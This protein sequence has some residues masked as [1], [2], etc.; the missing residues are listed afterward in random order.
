M[1][2]TYSSGKYIRNLVF[3]SITWI[4]FLA[5]F[6]PKLPYLYAQVW[7]SDDLTIIMRLFLFCI[8]LFV[9]VYCLLVPLY[10]L[11]CT[12]QFSHYDEDTIINYDNKTQT[13]HYKNDKCS[14]KETIFSLSDIVLIKRHISVWGPT[15]DCL[16]LKDEKKIYV[17]SLIPGFNQVIRQ[18]DKQRPDQDEGFSWGF[19]IH[20][21]LSTNTSHRTRS[22]QK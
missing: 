21:P 17:T 9:T 13:I 22:F 6:V 16:C 11:L 19:W 7:S 10:Y 4:L 15:Y 20:L 18:Y 3:I 14:F 1:I 12:I 5:L 8:L 2:F